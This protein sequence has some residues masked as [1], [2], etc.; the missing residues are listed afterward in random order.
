MPVGY[1]N[2]GVCTIV[3]TE[4]KAMKKLGKRHTVSKKNVDSIPSSPGL[5]VV[6]N[7]K[8]DVQYV[9]MSK[10]IKV[11]LSQHTSQRSIPGA[12]TFQVR[13]TN[14]RSEAEK[15]ESGY[16]RKYKPRYNVQKKR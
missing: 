14:S 11:R 16:I 3:K 15:L 12:H 10:N 7:T 6:R 1:D 2:G 5:Y 4:G 13:T 8:G 9:G